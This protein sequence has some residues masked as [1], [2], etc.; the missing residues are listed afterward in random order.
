MSL[1]VKNII[2]LNLLEGAKIVAGERGVN[3]EISWV[4]LM[5]ILDALD[6][7]QK[8]ELLITTGYRIDNEALYGDII[9]KL[10][11]KGVC[12]MAI[13]TGYYV[14]E[15][16]QYIKSSA[17]KYDFPI[18][19]LPP[20]LTFSHITHVLMENISLQLNLHDDSDFMNLRNKLCR[21]VNDN[22][23]NYIYRMME[24]RLKSEV[25]LF[26]LSVSHADSSI[27]TDNIMFRGIE[28]IKSYFA[29][30]G[31]E[32]RIERSG[33]KVLFIVSLNDN[34]SLQDIVFDISKILTSLS[35][36]FQMSFL[37]GTSI[38]ESTDN[39][40]SAFNEALTSEETLKK[41]GAQKGICSSSD[42][43]LFRLFEILHY[44]NYSIRFA[45]ETLKPVIDYD[46]IH[47]SS[48]LETLKLYLANE[49]NIT[50]TS[51]KLFIH[52]HTLKNRLNRINELCGV[53]F[54]NYY[55]R[56]RFS[57]AIFIYDYFII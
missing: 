51:N 19:E 32:M 56:I 49:C 22:S 5:E 29:G 28:K 30:I 54:K 14:D 4:N 47:K 9:P 25:Y 41:I 35:E 23:D 6:S 46:M 24:S 3:N 18:I 27:V 52:R 43:E 12:G 26:L 40:F 38:L 53:D 15:I 20:N 33:K 13:Q 17:D 39:I 55:S 34:M 31:S 16:P 45:Y 10:K 57:M 7:L 1:L 44:S 36:E 42:I 48:Y 21:I 50:N 37:I 8:G 11:N 2:E